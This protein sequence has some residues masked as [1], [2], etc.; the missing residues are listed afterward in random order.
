MPLAIRKVRA[1][2]FA[3]AI[4]GPLLAGNESTGQERWREVVALPSGSVVRVVDETG[5]VVTGDLAAA[6]DEEVVVTVKSQRLALPRDRVRR[7]ELRVGRSTGQRAKRGFLI[8]AAAGAAVAIATVQSNRG[9]WIP[10]LA[11]GWG[12]VGAAIG[13]ADGHSEW[14]YALVYEA[15][16]PRR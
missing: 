7:L 9:A 12:G 14:R 13:A 15:V 2:V 1:A 16:Q 10:L 11:I 3:L 5:R 4:S 6:T 8:G